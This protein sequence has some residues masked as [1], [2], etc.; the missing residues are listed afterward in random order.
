M[1]EVWKDIKGYE[2]KY[3]VSNL[4]RVKSLWIAHN[5]FDGIKKIQREKILAQRKDNLG[6]VSYGLFKNGQSKRVRA[7]KLVAEAFVGC[8]PKG[9]AI[10]HI[11]G[12]KSDNRV[13]NLEICT[14]SHNVKEAFRLGINK[15]RFGML[16][17]RAKKINQLDLDNNVINTFYG[18]YEAERKTKIGYSSIYRCLVGKQKQTQGYKWEYAKEE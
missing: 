4:G 8:I 17:H 11:N 14:Y 18:C 10:N 13:E 9:L 12:V 3:Q 2:G 5:T 16:N 6:Y 1:G 15:R 7:H